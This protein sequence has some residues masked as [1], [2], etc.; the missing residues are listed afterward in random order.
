MH[1]H[2]PRLT[3]LVVLGPPPNL[4]ALEVH[5]VPAERQDAAQPTPRPPR[6]EDQRTKE[7]VNRRR[8]RE[9]RGNRLRV[10]HGSLRVLLRRDLVLLERVPREERTPA[11]VLLASPIQP[12]L[13]H[14]QVT[15]NRVRPHGPGCRTAQPAPYHIF[16]DPVGR[17]C[18]DHLIRPKELGEIA[19]CLP[20]MS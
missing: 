18:I 6:Q 3:N 5:V 9:Q 10:E 17:Q 8:D 1:R 7:G 2:D 16:M 11:V 14:P 12:G 15:M 20:H 19:A 4:A 13:E